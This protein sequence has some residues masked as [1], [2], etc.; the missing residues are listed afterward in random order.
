MIRV[1]DGTIKAIE[2]FENIDR[3]S[4]PL[5]KVIGKTTRPRLIKNALSGTWLGHQFH[6]MATD[7][8]IGAWLSAGVIDLFGKETSN[9]TTRKLV[10]IG[11]IAAI[12]AAASGASDWSDT[13]GPDQRVGYL[14]ALANSAALSLQIISY[15]KRRHGKQKSAVVLST[16]ALAI[17]GLAAYLG[18]HLTL[19]RGMGVDHSAFQS[20]TEKWTK[21]ATPAELKNDKPYQVMAGETPVVLISHDDS[22]YALS[23]TCVHAGGPLA[24]GEVEGDC[25]TCPWHGSQ[26]R[27]SDG[28]VL[29]GPSSM[30]QPSWQVRIIKD[31]VEIRSVN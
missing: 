31:S 18:G 2:K 17:T 27:I 3:F 13:I 20:R 25:I 22:I 16:T 11:I 6:P 21:V 23:S 15:L 7:L 24:E 19:R 29:R 26:F 8:P 28:H 4:A 10:G 14:H 1:L 9:S 12:P 30:S 5:T